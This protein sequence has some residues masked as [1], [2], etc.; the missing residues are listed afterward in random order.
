LLGELQSDGGLVVADL[1]AG[2][3]TVL[4]LT[5]GQ[6]DV[7]LVVA[8]PTAKAADI[9][10]RAAR[11]AAN[12][13][14]RVI[15]IANRVSS[16]EDVAFVRDALDGRDVVVVPD[17]PGIARADREGGAPIDTARDGAGVRAIVR[18]AER[19]ARDA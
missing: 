18:L 4:R 16:E 13:G 15:A 17:D 2:T 10:A 7:V 12:R 9:A 19:L 1:E 11:T 6:V 8:Q 14:A 5:G 3:G